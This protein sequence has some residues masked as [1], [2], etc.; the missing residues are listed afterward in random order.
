MLY[1]LFFLICL[2]L[3]LPGCMSTSEVKT[4]EA[5]KNS[6]PDSY[7]TKQVLEKDPRARREQLDDTKIILEEARF[8]KATLYSLLLAEIALTRGYNSIAFD[9]LLQ[10]AQVTGEVAITRRVY[11]LANAKGVRSVALAAAQIWDTQEKDNPQVMRLY[12]D[13]L[14]FAKAFDVAIQVASRLRATKKKLTTTV[15]ID[16]VRGALKEPGTDY[17]YMLQNLTAIQNSYKND[18]D[19]LMAR[20]MLRFR[21]GQLSKAT[22]DARRAYSMFKNES[23][24][25]EYVHIL[26]AGG[27]VKA[28]LKLLQ[29]RRHKYPESL[30][31][32]TA[33]TDKLIDQQD[34][35]TARTELQTLLKK[36]PQHIQGSI[37]LI[38]IDLQLDNFEQARSRLQYLQE[39]DIS[40]SEVYFLLGSLEKQVGN[41]DRAIQVFKQIPPGV[42]FLDS[43]HEIVRLLKS[44][45]L[46]VEAQNR[47]R[48]LRREHQEYSLE[49]YRLE[50]QYHDSS[51]IKIYAFF[52]EALRAHPDDLKLLYMRSQV[53]LENK[54][55]VAA[56]DDLRRII[57]LDAKH[58]DAINKLSEILI[59]R[60]ERYVEVEELFRLAFTIHKQESL[61]D[62]S[63]GWLFYLQGDFINAIELLQKALTT[64]PDA[65]ITARLGEALWVAGQRARAKEVWTQGLDNWP[66]ATILRSTIYRLTGTYN[67]GT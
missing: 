27:A 50:G 28:A 32:A 26:Y 46:F 57:E 19:L 30:L 10:Q 61:L 23:T 9:E 18:A 4:S 1:K 25:V 17:E 22:E 63:M 60:P 38:K 7:L 48:E 58:L 55:I 5:D 44:Q 6:D 40:N 24:I 51:D 33:Y 31:V 62:A 65:S 3:I 52:N 35:V 67:V 41:V 43:Q 2:A 14:N 53:S 56:E 49:L 54:N 37:N 64:Q 13:E 16:I 45:G 12:I 47:L 11:R 34:F 21:L 59:A 66:G 20:A 29:K 36:W 42:L 39:Q 15:F 8:P